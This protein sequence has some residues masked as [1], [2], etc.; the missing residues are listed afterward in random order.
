M[1]LSLFLTASL[2]A[3]SILFNY[4]YSVSDR[5]AF[6]S[7]SLS[8]GAIL[9]GFTATSQAILMTLPEN[10]LLLRLRVS[11]YISDLVNCFIA[12][13]IGASAF[14]ILNLAGFF[15]AT[16]NQ[17]FYYVWLFSLLYCITTLF[18]LSKLMILILRHGAK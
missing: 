7:A 8:L 14:V 1:V 11:G 10:G 2:A 4:S 16:L 9:T 5:S 18:R 6:L 12:A 13:I 15:I 17:K 3:S